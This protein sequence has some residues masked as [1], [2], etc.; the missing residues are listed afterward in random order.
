M[1]GLPE[2]KTFVGI[3]LPKC[4]PPLQDVY[5]RIAYKRVQDNAVTGVV[6]E[7]KHKTAFAAAKSV[8]ISL[9][10]CLHIEAVKEYVGEL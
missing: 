3:K 2:R 4:T 10:E 8:G 6:T 9:M 1:A 5:W 7:Y